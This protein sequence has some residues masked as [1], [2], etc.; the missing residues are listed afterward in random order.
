MITNKW[1][2][3]ESHALPGRPNDNGTNPR[4]I[5]SE[6]FITFYVH[7]SGSDLFYHMFTHKITSFFCSRKSGTRM[8]LH[9]FNNRPTDLLLFFTI[10]II[11]IHLQWIMWTDVE[12]QVVYSNVFLI[13]YK[14]LSFCDQRIYG[15]QALRS[16]IVA[17][18]LVIFL[19]SPLL[20]P[21]AFL[22]P[23]HS[24]TEPSEPRFDRP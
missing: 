18:T 15:Q 9:R 20:S 12:N 3:W 24:H 22:H 5:S 21:R 11:Y 4:Q 16:V 10:T 7:T 6:N 14:Q 23:K 13:T 19:L 17:Y 1:G 2:E 8:T